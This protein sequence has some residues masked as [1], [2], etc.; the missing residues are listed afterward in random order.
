[1]EDWRR[2]WRDGFAPLLPTA[3]LQA[4]REA[5]VSDD[6][7]LIQYETTHPNP[8]RGVGDLPCEGACAVAYCG[9]EIG[10]PGTVDAVQEWFAEVCFA[11]DQKLDEP[12]GCRWFLDFWDSAPR[13]EA[14]RLLLPEVEKE[15]SKRLVG[16]G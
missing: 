8:I 7:R 6:G 1:M 5:L 12:A 11:C 2:V 10:A 4:L 3:G 16:V 13:G 14:I 9:W 15:L